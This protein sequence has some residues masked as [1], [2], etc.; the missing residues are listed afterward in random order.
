MPNSSTLA[1]KT[2]WHSGL[3]FFEPA[4][5]KVHNVSGTPAVKSR[6]SQSRRIRLHKTGRFRKGR[7]D[8]LAASTGTP[9]VLASNRNRP[10][11]LTH[12]RFLPQ[13]SIELMFGDGMS[14]TLPVGMLE[15]PV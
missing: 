5:G 12:A 7:V 6:S 13:S 10:D 15:M 4:S 9:I 8:H 1:C 3:I 14:A 11:Y 2:Q